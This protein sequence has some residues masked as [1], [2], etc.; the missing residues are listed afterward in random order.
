M[1]KKILFLMVVQI[2]CGRMLKPFDISMNPKMYHRLCSPVDADERESSVGFIQFFTGIM[3]YFGESE[4]EP[5]H[6][7]DDYY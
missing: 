3:C 4:N 6:K 1:M 5:N 2:V 7:Y